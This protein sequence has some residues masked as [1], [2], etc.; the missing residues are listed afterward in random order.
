MKVVVSILLLIGII[1]A[2]LVLCAWSVLL[3]S[4]LMFFSDSK[5]CYP[6]IND[7]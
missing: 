1:V 5:E 2:I 7:L 6:D 4:W 3:G